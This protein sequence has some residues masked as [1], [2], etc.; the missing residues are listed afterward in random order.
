[1][2][3][4]DRMK[5]FKLGVKNFQT[6]SVIASFL[7]TVFIVGC[8][9]VQQDESSQTFM[10]SSDHNFDLSA[11]V[12]QQWQGGD[13][14]YAANG[15]IDHMAMVDDNTYSIDSTPDII[16]TD[17]NGS[18]RRHNDFKKWADQGDWASI[19]GYYVSIVES[20]TETSEG[21]KN[22]FDVGDVFNAQSEV[23][24][25][26]KLYKR[27]SPSNTHSSQLVRHAYQYLYNID[28]DADGGWWSWPKDI[29]HNPNL[30]AISEASFVRS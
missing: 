11:A 16:D 8:V 1:M 4:D 20:A 24:L 10:V 14:V 25:V 22:S 23:T 17:R 5:L 28:L 2:V 26:P 29:L 12:N 21:S 30:K 27:N 18:I 7:V 3:R 9:S 6:R 19:D 13:I 15:Y